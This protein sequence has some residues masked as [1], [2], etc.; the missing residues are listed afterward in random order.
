MRGFVL[1]SV[2]TCR[3][4]AARFRLGDSHSCTTQAVH[5]TVIKPAAGAV[6]DLGRF[7]TTRQWFVD[8]SDPSKRSPS[9]MTFDRETNQIVTQD[10]RVWI[11]A[12]SRSTRSSSIASYGAACR[13]PTG[14]NSMPS[15]RASST[16]RPT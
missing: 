10:S 7:L 15:A 6:A 2:V 3:P 8:P 13:M 1:Y 9:V 16:T 11:A 12:R 5:Y 14:R 4:I